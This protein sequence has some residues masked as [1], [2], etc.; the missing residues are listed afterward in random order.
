MTISP[1]VA[2]LRALVGPE[3]LQLP[4][5]ALLPRDGTGRILLVRHADGGLWGVVG[6]AIELDEAPDEAVVREAVEEIGARPTGCRLLGAFGG[7]DYRVEYGN[8]DRA[9]YVVVAYESGL[10]GDPVPD[11][12]EVTDARWVDPAACSSVPLNGLASALLRDAG[13]AGSL[14]HPGNAGLEGPVHR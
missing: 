9:S 12:D 10:S 3:L 14:R 7:P 4:S 13:V 11:G 6:G 2:R 5:V 8:G 1:H